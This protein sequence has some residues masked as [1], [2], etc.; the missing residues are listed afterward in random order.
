MRVL[1]FS[2]LSYDD[3]R[4]KGGNWVNS[5]IDLLSSCDD[6]EIA[7]AYISSNEFARKV[8]KEKIAYYPIYYKESIF[9]KIYYHLVGKLGCMQNSM[10]VDAIIKDFRPDIIQLF[11]IETPFGAILRKISSIPIVVH[12]Q[13]IISSSYYYYY[14]M[15]FSKIEAWIY[16]PLR[17]KLRFNTPFDLYNRLVYLS[18]VEKRNFL[19]YKYYLGRTKWDYQLCSML[20]ENPKYYHCDEVLRSEFYKYE[21]QW[22]DWKTIIISTIM[23]GELYKGFDTILKTASILQKRNIDFVW[24]V[25]GVEENFPFRKGIESHY[26]LN[27]RR[28]NVY[29]KGKK[30]AEELVSALVNS[31][32]YVHSSHIDN[33]PNALCEAMILGVPSIATYVGGVPSII[34]DGETGWLVPDSECFQLAY[35]ISTLYLDRNHMECISK[36]SR[37]TALKRHNPSLIIRQ[38]KDAYQDILSIEDCK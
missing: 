7:V 33:S 12:L 23:N 31:T 19:T 2:Y 1:V 13:G 8:I 17:D 16:S 37:N 30:N 9:R 26:K 32:Y 27:F 24:N 20:A 18:G 36:E 28:N 5:L 14:P 34:R 11:G 4:Y 29:F 38:L 15:G 21:W 22:N 25:Y 3:N 6:L 10:R 35:L